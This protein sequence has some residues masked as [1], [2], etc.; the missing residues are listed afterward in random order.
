MNNCKLMEISALYNRTFLTAFL[1]QPLAFPLNYELTYEIMVS[2]S[3]LWV[4]YATLIFAYV[5]CRVAHA[6]NPRSLRSSWTKTKFQDSQTCYIE[7]THYDIEL[8]F[9]FTIQIYVKTQD[10]NISDISSHILN[11]LISFLEFT[12]YKNSGPLER[13]P[14]I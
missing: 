9:C 4:C 14:K 7:K 11:Y 2:M 5:T 12:S 3:S 1:W 10:V 6:F 13:G 8:S